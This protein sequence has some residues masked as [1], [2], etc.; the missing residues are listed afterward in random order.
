MDR[1]TAEGAIGRNGYFKRYLQTG[2]RM[3]ATH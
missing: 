1:L 3:E 2:Q